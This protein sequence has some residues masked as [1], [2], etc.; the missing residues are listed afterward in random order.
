MVLVP[1]PRQEVALCSCGQ[2]T[3]ISEGFGVHMQIIYK[4]KDHV[5]LTE[6]DEDKENDD[7]EDR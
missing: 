1:E 7:H 6:E 3:L 2:A 5:C 4:N